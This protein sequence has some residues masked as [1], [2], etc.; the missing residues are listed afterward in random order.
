MIIL[1]NTTLTMQPAM[2][3]GFFLPNYKMFMELGLVYVLCVNKAKNNS[4]PIGWYHNQNGVKPHL[5]I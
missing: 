4:K 3:F 5:R 1:S 2:F